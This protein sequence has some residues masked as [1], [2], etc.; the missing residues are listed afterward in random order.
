MGKSTLIELICG[1][2]LPNQGGIYIGS[3]NIFNDLKDWR[4]KIGYVPQNVFL[5]QDTISKNITFFQKNLE[6][7]F[8]DENKISDLI[9]LVK[10]DEFIENLKEKEKNYS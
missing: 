1:L 4:K 2:I 5:I 8:E 10:L 3:E 9:N 7:S 6:N